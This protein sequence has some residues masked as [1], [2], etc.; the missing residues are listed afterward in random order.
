MGAKGEVGGLG[1]SRGVG[2]SGRE[3]EGRRSR[4]EG[5]KGGRKE[6]GVRRRE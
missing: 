3:W 1:G 4:R 6:G 2:G 5:W